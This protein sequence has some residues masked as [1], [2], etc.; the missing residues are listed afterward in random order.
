MANQKNINTRIIHKHDIEANWLLAANFTPKQGE[1]IVYDIDENHT[2]QR[3][4]IGD[5]NSNVN[6]LPFSGEGEK[7][8]KQ[9]DEPTN[10]EDG[11]LW[12][13][14]DQDEASSNGGLS[15]EL[16]WENA[17]LTSSFS[18]QTID[19]DLSNYS[20]VIVEYMF[21]TTTQNYL[22]I[23][24]FIDGVTRS[25]AVTNSSTSKNGFRS[26]TVNTNSISFNDARYAGD[27]DNN[28]VIPAKIYGIKGEIK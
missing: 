17:S 4:K 22:N 10:V 13:D 24:A 1:I 21:Y 18:A 11:T 7:I 8:Y 19:L 5:G 20:W 15:M 27:T 6:I 2:Y 3:F 12:I 16:L 23:F 28:Y 9:N 25:M 14:L 26:L